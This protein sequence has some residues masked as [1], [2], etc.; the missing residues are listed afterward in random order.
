MKFLG[1]LMFVFPMFAQ[2]ADMYGKHHLCIKNPQDSY[3]TGDA[4]SAYPSC[5]KEY[6]VIHVPTELSDISVFQLKIQSLE[7]QLQTCQATNVSNQTSCSQQTSFYQ[8]T[9]FFGG[10]IA[11]QDVKWAYQQLFQIAILV[12]SGVLWRAILV[13]F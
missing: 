5:S 1:F 9:S 12:F 10:Q 6:A 13:T 11:V 3:M 8:S 4:V 2:A 7:T